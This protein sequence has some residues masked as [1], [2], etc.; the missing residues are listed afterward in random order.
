MFR[1]SVQLRKGGPAKVALLI[2]CGLFLLLLGSC[3]EKRDYKV[4]SFFFDGVPDP[5]ARP[6]DQTKATVHF[7]TARPLEQLPRLAYQHKPFALHQCD[8]CHTADHKQLTK[9]DSTDLCVKCHTNTTH[10]FTVMHGPVSNGLCLWCHEAHESD[11]PHLLK[12]NGSDLC[13]QCHDRQLLPSDNPA[14]L[15][16]KAVCLDCHLGH[17]GTTP[18]LLRNPQSPLAA[19]PTTRLTTAPAGGGGS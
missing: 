15:S 14:H 19:F 16:E 3:Q 17:G 1:P 5:Y 7:V 6:I 18:A 12:S 2:V 9:L 11:V 8:Q 4:L 13:L 10:E